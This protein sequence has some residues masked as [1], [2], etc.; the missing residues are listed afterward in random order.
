MNSPQLRPRSSSAGFTLIEVLVALAVFVLATAALIYGIDALFAANS[1][2]QTRMLDQYA[3]Q[4]VAAL[5]LGNPATLQNSNNITLQRGA[6]PSNGDPVLTAW[7]N[8]TQA[9]NPFLRQVNI[10]T[11][12]A[13]CPPAAACLL[14]LK[15][16]TQSSTQSAPTVR[17]YQI[18][19]GY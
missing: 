19:E 1:R 2:A 11:A 15:L 10:I 7:W 8:S 13:P 4:N 17:T 3:A 9:Q 6:A 16:T 18:Q 12:P 5:F 14:T